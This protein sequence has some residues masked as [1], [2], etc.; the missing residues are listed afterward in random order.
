MPLEK[1]SQLNKELSCYHCG[2]LTRVNQLRAYPGGGWICAECS[3]KFFGNRKV[4][5][6][7]FS[8]VE[9][10]QKKFNIVKHIDPYGD[11]GAEDEQPSSIG[12]R[13]EERKTTQ[14]RPIKR[15][16]RKSADKKLYKCAYCTFESR[17]YN[18]DDIC[19]NCGRKR[20]V[21]VISTSELLNK[22]ENE[23]Y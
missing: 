22:M 16:L 19:P 4:N 17:H 9:P 10:V 11:E 18:D 6:E 8:K 14:T 1:N 20:L 15:S 23:P 13:L 7:E 21:K 5:Q 2:K 3:E 12:S